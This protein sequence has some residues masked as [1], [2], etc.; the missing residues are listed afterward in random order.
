[1]KYRH[2][3]IYIFTILFGLL[4]SWLTA[5]EIGMPFTQNY[6][7]SVYKAG[8]Q[9]WAIV[10]D[11]RGV[12]Y[13]GN[14]NGLLE[15][16]GKNWK[17][18][19]ISN[20]LSVT[21]L[22]I[23]EDG[24]VYVGA[25]GEF[26]YLTPNPKTGEM[27]Y[28]SL[29]DKLPDEEKNFTDIW[30][31]YVSKD[32]VYFQS[33]KCL[34]R[35]RKDQ[36]KIWRPTLQMPE[37]AFHFSFSVNNK[38][39]IREKG[40]GLF[41]LEN[42]S[43]HFIQGGGLFSES[44]IYTMLPFDETGKIL[45]GTAE[46]GLFLYDPTDA[47][48]PIFPLYSDA[49]TYLAKHQIYH[50]IRFSNNKKE[51]Q[52][53]L[54]TIRGGLVILDENGQ[55]VEVLNRN[56]NL[57]DNMVLFAYQDRQH[58]LWLGLN[59][60]I[61]RVEIR[62]PL[63][64]WDETS[65][66]E[67]SVQSITR[68]QN[69]L[70][71]AT[72]VGVYYLKDNRF[73][74]IKNIH[75]QSWS[76]LKFTP[77]KNDRTQDKLL[78]GTNVGIYE[79]RLDGNDGFYGKQ[80]NNYNSFILYPSKNTPNKIYVGLPDGLAVMTWK[81]NLWLNYGKIQDIDA[82]EVRSIAEDSNGTIWA[83]TTYSGI[84]RLKFAQSNDIKPI[85]VYQFVLSDNS[86]SSLNGVQIYNYSNQVL[87]RTVG[88]LYVYDDELNKFKPEKQIS[89][90]FP[91]GLQGNVRF[92]EDQKGN[93]WLNVYN[94]QE[95]KIEVIRKIKYATGKTR[96]YRDSISL[97]RLPELDIYA[98]YPDD[99]GITWI[100]SVEGLFQ[101]NG[102]KTRKDYNEKFSALIRKV[103]LKRDSLLFSGTHAEIKTSDWI[104]NKYISSLTQAWRNVPELPFEYNSLTFHFS[105][106]NYDK[107][108]AT[109]YS[110]FLQGYD[111]T[112]SAWTTETKK[113][114][115]NLSEATYKF[116]VKARNIYGTESSEAMYQFRIKPPWYLTFG[117]FLSYMALG[118][119]LVRIAVVINGRR[120]RKQNEEL[121]QIV[122]KRTNEITEKNTFLEKQ[123]N[124]ITEKTKQ[125][126]S[127]TKKLENQKQTLEKQTHKLKS[128]KK[129]LE[130]Q[131]S[132]LEQKN[133]E[134]TEERDNTQRAYDNINLLSEIG[135]EI[136]ST[137]SLENI[138]RTVYDNIS[139]RMNIQI[140]GI[141]L[142]LEEDRVIAFQNFIKGDTTQNFQVS[143]ADENDLTVW[144][145]YNREEVI[146]KKYIDEYKYYIPNAPFPGRT[147]FAQSIV[148]LPLMNQSQSLGVMTVQS[149]DEDAFS[150][151]DI[152]L[153]KNLAV[154]VG[155]ALS[156]AESYAQITRQHQIIEEKN[157]EISKTS[158][159][160]INSINYA[161][162][163]Q[164]AMLPQPQHLQQS[165]PDSFIFWQPRDVV[166]GD[167]YWFAEVDET[168]TS[169]KQVVSAVDC[170]GHGVPGAFMSMIGNDLLNDIVNRR[171][172]IRPER[173][174][175]EMHR[176][177]VKGLK[178]METS[179][180]DG[181]DMSLCV[182][183]KK[184]N[185]VEFAG[186]KNPL[187]Y[188]RQNEMYEIKGDKQPIGLMRRE[189]SERD[190]R[191]HLIEVE[192]PTWFYLFSDG[193]QDQFGG[194]KGRKYMKRRMKEFLLKIHKQLPEFQHKSLKDN[195][196]EWK[197]KNSQT[198]DILVIGFRLE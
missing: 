97:K 163:I 11:H 56:T 125:L 71:V 76:L 74:P 55:F 78:V 58:A 175:N 79:I 50:G 92:T 8:S 172:I 182:I 32:G 15:F 145:L 189:M 142:Y 21:S 115:T 161:S 107:P 185:L 64:Y 167:F 35:F 124:E 102:K 91:N 184:T 126:E 134:I 67:G 169:K 6:A 48:M 119:I 31:T 188:I 1:M 138:R 46:Q 162:R 52:F 104:D 137:L 140:F 164:S 112:W 106:T 75:S 150:G 2:F 190:F 4:A 73:H 114:Y 127:Q 25:Y 180:R 193:Y 57:Q 89:K 26:G 170:T 10:Q 135:K 149:Y 66:L 77:K 88:G 153:L 80:I 12:M 23:D 38:L 29:S 181:M 147:G 27:Q 157:I 198:D 116:R 81:N 192:E 39:Y 152:N 132:L 16:D 165:L 61:S 141:G 171:R 28:V 22:A 51:P 82:F 54:T 139:A 113:E 99:K 36:Y 5:Q 194:P 47:E 30:K 196:N 13:V 17:L 120:L 197:G 7:P 84:I 131:H 176:G 100:G 98:V 108:S 151:N 19:P 183:D 87:I 42:D 14:T 95:S 148:C 143:I 105:A 20:N 191:G 45:I 156:N 72:G 154:Y 18:I 186:A 41:C 195:I 118:G 155:I 166:S 60:G 130:K 59:N 90:I 177:V 178:Q 44:R 68:Y 96:Y 144:S 93:L 110:Y 111:E 133:R 83:G 187:F 122:A 65:G 86:E 69:T 129:E 128:H 173:I 136:T 174:L 94:E 3:R 103:Y 160:I 43:L 117:A 179:N 121:E 159:D 53:A 33:Y 101:Y 34:I 123:K 146:I 168:P 85:D 37:A 158:Q 63:R 62:L 9:N 40:V 49:N 70:F 24:V 109:E